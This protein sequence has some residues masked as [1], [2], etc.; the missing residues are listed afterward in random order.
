MVTSYKDNTILHICILGDYEVGLR[1]GAWWQGFGVGLRG[2][3][4]GWGFGGFGGASDVSSQF[5]GQGDFH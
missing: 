5:S 1:G 2:G 3:A 4:S